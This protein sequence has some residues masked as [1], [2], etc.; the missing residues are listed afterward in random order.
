[1]DI[2]KYLMSDNA[3]IEA[4]KAEKFDIIVRDA[5]SWPTKLLTQMLNVPEVDMVS[6][7]VLQPFYEAFYFVPNPIAY[8]PQFTTQLSPI[9]VR[10]SKDGSILHA[11]LN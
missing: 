7:G 6:A 9:M 10:I 3:T 11:H 2:G 1:M 5:S 4:L 8:Y